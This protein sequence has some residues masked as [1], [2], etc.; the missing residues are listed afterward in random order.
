MI[1]W[2]LSVVVMVLYHRQVLY[3]SHQDGVEAGD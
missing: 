3:K 1:H 2:D